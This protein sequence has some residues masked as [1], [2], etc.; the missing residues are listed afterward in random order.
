M[1]RKKEE[2]EEDEPMSPTGRM[3]QTPKFNVCIVIFLG[4]YTKIDPILFKKGVQQALVKHPRFC[5]IL[6]SIS[7][8]DK[9]VDGM[10]LSILGIRQS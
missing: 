1:A 5:S 10:I 8:S 3:M 4:F 2:E 6:V 7:F 9:T